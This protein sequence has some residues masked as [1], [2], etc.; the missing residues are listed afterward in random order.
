MQ[1]QKDFLD[2]SLDRVNYWLQFAEAKNAAMIA[3]VVA[4]L[5]VI[6]GGDVINHLVL[7]IMITVIYVISLLLSVISFYPKYKKNVWICDGTYEVEDNLLFWKDISK[8]S[9]NDYLKAVSGKIFQVENERFD[10]DLRMY[11]EEIITN[12]RIA[13]A[14]YMLFEAA[15]KFVAFA[16]VLLPIFIIIAE[17]V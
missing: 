11:A 4:M 3:F 16:T 6:Y 2:K 13:K 9:V 15:I 12:A 1:G 8:Y 17:Y 14:K 10:L 5:A 7:K